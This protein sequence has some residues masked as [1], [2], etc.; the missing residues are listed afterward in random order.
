MHHLPF[1][2][3]CRAT[4]Q[5]TC[6]PW[7]SAMTSCKCQRHRRSAGAFA[8]GWRTARP[9]HMPPL[10]R[11]DCIHRAR[12]ATTSIE[13]PPRDSAMFTAAWRNS[14]RF[15]P[16]RLWCAWGWPLGIFFGTV[17]RGTSGRTHRY[18]GARGRSLPAR[19]ARA[20]ADSLSS[21]RLGTGSTQD[22]KKYDIRR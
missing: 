10:H 2:L 7:P 9:A 22:Q 13:L 11:R 3:I 15:A 17:S 16:R 18:P 20:T 4:K 21:F 12:G 5:T 8:R 6:W 14:L 19:A 1:Q